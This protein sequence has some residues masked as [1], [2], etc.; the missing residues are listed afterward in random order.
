MEIFGKIRREYRS[1]P[2]FVLGHDHPDTD[3]VLATE[4]FC[5]AAARA[6]IDAR[7]V[8]TGQ[9]DPESARGYVR[10]GVDPSGWLRAEEL[11]GDALLFL[12]DCHETPHAGSVIGCMD[13]HPAA[14]APQG[15][16]F[17]DHRASS[18]TL[19][20]FRAA[21]EEGIPLSDADELAALRSV[22]ADTESLLSPKFLPSDRPWIEAM[23][24][25]HGADERELI[26]DGL[27][28]SDLALPPERLAVG[29][30]K[31][32]AYAG[33]SGRVRRAAS[34]HIEAEGISPELVADAL[35]I[36]SRR[37]AEEDLYEWVLITVEPL[38]HRSAVYEITAA[39]V[40]KTLY[41]RFISRSVDVLPALEEKLTSMP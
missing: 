31:Y 27:C 6:G 34:S 25:K 5:R 19:M 14:N 18:A 29:G 22:Y 13:H 39:G 30:L 8:S 40:E 35:E 33:L 15:E 10:C 20:I 26:R 36:L 12:V 7:R 9:A 24:R 28:F 1:R 4:L 3:T 17:V 16:L 21:A 23:I 38:S 41:D 11:T 2:V 32:H 37:R